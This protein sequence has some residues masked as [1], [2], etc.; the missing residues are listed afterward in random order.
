MVDFF[1]GEFSIN[2]ISA[3]KE[4]KTI[5]QERPDIMAPKRKMNPISPYAFS[6][7]VYYDEHAYENT[8]ITLN[9]AI[10]AHEEDR[11]NYRRKLFYALSTGGYVDI[12]FYFD[13][14]VIYRCALVE[15]YSYTNK[16]FYEGAQTTEVKLSV[17]PYKTKKTKPITIIGSGG[18]ANAVVGTISDI[19][20]A[21]P[22]EFFTSFPTF[23]LKGAGEVKITAQCGDITKE[24]HLVNLD[25]SV[26]VIIDNDMKFVYGLLYNSPTT[27]PVET[28]ANL[29]MKTREFM[30]LPGTYTIGASGTVNELIVTPN[31]RTLV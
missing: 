27:S 2:G 8:E 7:A 30:E 28:N 11:A 4:F 13:P 12:E 18:K 14:G 31:W 25:R 1:P 20:I 9:L 16:Y 15:N 3:F 22:G 26:P 5:I 10:L 17:A 21:S 6:G 24:Y 29:K 19:T 23:R